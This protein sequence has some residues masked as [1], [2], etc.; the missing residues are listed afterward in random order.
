MSNQFQTR[1]DWLAQAIAELR[2]VFSALN[3]PLPDSTFGLP[4][5]SHPVMPGLLR[6]VPWVSIGLPGPLLTKPMRF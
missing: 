6:T 3:H 2:P 1:E 4:V 5:V